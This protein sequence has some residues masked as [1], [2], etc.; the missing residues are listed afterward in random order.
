[1]AEHFRPYNVVE[2]FEIAR[3]GGKATVTLEKRG[4]GSYAFT[5]IRGNKHTTG[6]SLAL[7]RLVE[8]LVEERE[9][10]PETTITEGK[11]KAPNIEYRSP[12]WRP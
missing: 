7:S 2:T 12:S 6:E 3:I 1:M 5:D 8:I 4:D 9:P 10:L 11:Q